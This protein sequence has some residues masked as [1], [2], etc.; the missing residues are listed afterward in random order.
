MFS[1][2]F[3]YRPR[4]AP[5]NIVIYVAATAERKG[6]ILCRDFSIAAPGHLETKAE[7]KRANGIGAAAAGR[8]RRDGSWKA[9]GFRRAVAKRRLFAETLAAAG[10]E[11]KHYVR[12][13][14]E[15]EKTNNL[16]I[17]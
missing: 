15:E 16:E 3:D 14:E 6:E 8:G 9:G 13:L 2:E 5:G 17:M 4:L 7:Q 10:R 1:M 11:S 12:F